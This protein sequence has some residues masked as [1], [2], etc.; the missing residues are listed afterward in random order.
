MTGSLPC[1]NFPWPVATWVNP[2]TLCLLAVF[3]SLCANPHP[4]DRGHLRRVS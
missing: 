3:G 1:S 2:S 4:W